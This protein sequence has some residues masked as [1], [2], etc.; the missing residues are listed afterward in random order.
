LVFIEFHEE[1][2]RTIDG[3]RRGIA[4]IDA[5]GLNREELAEIRRDVLAQIRLL[6]DCRELFWHHT[7]ADRNPLHAEQVAA[8]DARLVQCASDSAQHAAMNRAILR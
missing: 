6:I 1:Y 8:I 4:T 2:V 7:A 5:L 3:N